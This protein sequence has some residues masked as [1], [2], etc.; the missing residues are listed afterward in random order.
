MILDMNLFNLAQPD[1]LFP[2]GS[3]VGARLMKFSNRYTAFSFY[4]IELKLCRMLRK[5][6]SAQLLGVGFFDFPPGA[7]WG[8]PREILKLIHSLQFLSD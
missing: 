4:T 8:E 6:Q 5:D 1:F 3:T 7:L 2:P